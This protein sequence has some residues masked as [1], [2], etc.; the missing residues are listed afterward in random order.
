[1][2]NYQE[3]KLLKGTFINVM[4]ECLDFGEVKNYALN[5]IPEL[6]PRPGLFPKK[7]LNTMY[8]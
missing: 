5:C 8:S 2:L 6:V 3:T 7:V 1:M 4:D